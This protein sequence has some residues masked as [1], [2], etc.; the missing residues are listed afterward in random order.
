MMSST[1]RTATACIRDAERPSLLISILC[2]L[3][4]YGLLGAGCKSTDKPES[5]RFASVE[6]RGNTPGQIRDVVVAVFQE[7]GYILARTGMTKFVFEQKGS[8][9]NN[10]AYGN[11]IGDT[12]IW[13]RVKVAVVPVVEATYRIECHAFML[14]GRGESTEEEIRITGLH[15][16]PYQK[17]LDEVA[18]RLNGSPVR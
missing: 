16:G 15:S 2:A 10:L 9:W 7:H 6:I 3:C 8:S 17:L 1:Q 11:W 4:L 5:A 13:I 18:G 14:R 12:P